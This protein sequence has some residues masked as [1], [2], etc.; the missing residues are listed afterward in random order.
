MCGVVVCAPQNGMGISE[1]K[2]ELYTA[3]AGVNPAVC[4]PVCL[5]V[6]TNNVKLREHPKYKGVRAARPPQKEYDEF[7][8]EFMEA[9]RVSWVN[10]YRYG[11]LAVCAQSTK[12]E[13]SYGWTF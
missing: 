7:V 2:I 13:A 1:G 9:I 4:L 5:D 12:V 8:Q 3:A 11:I 6:G 10:G